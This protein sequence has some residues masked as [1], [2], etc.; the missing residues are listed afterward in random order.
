MKFVFSLDEANQVKL[1]FTLCDSA[2]E[3]DLLLEGYLLFT[4]RT[5]M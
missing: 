5:S 2:V 3:Q 4:L 1:G